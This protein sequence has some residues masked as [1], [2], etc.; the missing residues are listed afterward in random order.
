[1]TT[2]LMI[3][4]IFVALFYFVRQRDRFQRESD[5]LLHNILPDTVAERLKV[6]D[7]MIAESFDAASVLFADIV[8]FTPISAEMAP[9]ELVSLLNEVFGAFDSIADELGMEKI[10]TVGDEYMAAAGVPQP[11]HDHAHAAAELALRLRDLVLTQSFGGLTLPLRIGV[12][13]GPVTAGIIGTAK[14]AYD[15]WGDTVNVASRMESTGFPARSRSARRRTSRSRT[16][17]SANCA[18][19]SM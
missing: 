5:N 11:R 19:R 15:L 3:T 1:M 16:T 6:D 18:A 12:N 10:K 9:E 7:G 17:S 8:G 13:S 2:V 4:M 14:F